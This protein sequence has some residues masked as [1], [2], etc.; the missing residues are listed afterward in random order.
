[1]ARALQHGK[2]WKIS[3]QEPN[4]TETR[5]PLT[6]DIKLRFYVF[7]TLKLAVLEDVT[8]QSKRKLDTLGKADFSSARE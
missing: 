2:L 6:S 8:F 4:L 1:M 5:Q 3:L 7:Q